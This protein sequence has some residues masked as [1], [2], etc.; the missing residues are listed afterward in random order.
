MMS[1][2][3]KFSQIISQNTKC[4]RLNKVAEY[5]Q[6]EHDYQ[7]VN[8]SR[9][10]W[11]NQSF[12]QHW[13]NQLI[14]YQEYRSL[15][16]NNIKKFLTSRVIGDSAFS[17]LDDNRPNLYPSARCRVVEVDGQVKLH[18]LSLD[19]IL[20]RDYY[21]RFSLN[22]PLQSPE[23]TSNSQSD[24]PEA[25]PSAGILHCDD[26]KSFNI[27]KHSVV[28][29]KE[30]TVYDYTTSDLVESINLA[31]LYVTKDENEVIRLFVLDEDGYQE[32]NARVNS[33]A[34]PLRNSVDELG[35]LHLIDTQRYPVGVSF[36]NI[37]F[38]NT[39][40]YFPG[41]YIGSLIISPRC[42][43]VN[44]S[45][46]SHIKTLQLKLREICNAEKVVLHLNSSNV[47]VDI[48][49]E[50]DLVIILSAGES[51]GHIHLSEYLSPPN[52]QINHEI[53]VPLNHT[54]NNAISV[55]SN[56]HLPAVETL[57]VDSSWVYVR[58][59]CDQYQYLLVLDRLK[60]KLFKNIESD[61]FFIAYEDAIGFHLRLR[62][63]A[64]DKSEEIL[65]KTALVEAISKDEIQQLL[66]EYS[67]AKYKPE[68]LKYS[69]NNL[70]QFEILFCRESQALLDAIHKI[71]GCEQQRL[72]YGISR[73]IGNLRHIF[74]DNAL[75]ISFLRDIVDEHL[76]VIS[77]N[78]AVRKRLVKN[79]KNK[80]NIITE[81]VEDYLGNSQFG[82]VNLAT[83]RE[84]IKH[85]LHTICNRVF[86]DITF[87]KEITTYYFALRLVSK[88]HFQKS[89]SEKI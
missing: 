2:L 9:L 71:V 74:N 24:E 42:W 73:V 53:I 70:Q 49:S 60:G 6:K 32:I 28:S 37:F 66:H 78:G 65:L 85:L 83:K 22:T 81:Q 10:F 13:K 57:N 11:K 58:M 31:Q 79:F 84:P 29:N 21:A 59:Y 18:V 50:D 80:R 54:W 68:Y 38:S 51:K 56:L 41:L 46:V 87:E 35:L 88:W 16:V 64:G 43:T 48:S 12:N 34:N 86:A 1:D 8:L 55:D 89:G 47:L 39:E 40:S 36:D 3:E 30:I 7:L 52:D 76:T 75:V 26:L 33:L 19:N 45:D 5:I 69:L 17:L 27:S 20:P 23:F 61:W 67:F 4:F 25:I 72:S 44:I 62:I 77:K 63:K 14:E 15:E 82:T